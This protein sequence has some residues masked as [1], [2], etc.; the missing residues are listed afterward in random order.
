[1]ARSLA[2]RASSSLVWVLTA[3][4]LGGV[5]G[6]LTAVGGQ[7]GVFFWEGLLFVHCPV[8]VFNAAVQ[9]EKA[10]ELRHEV[11]CYGAAAMVRI[12]G[13]YASAGGAYD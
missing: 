1:M 6:L 11:L 4:F 5:S 9:L 10:V 8:E 3:A 2:S 7:V 13:S 12:G